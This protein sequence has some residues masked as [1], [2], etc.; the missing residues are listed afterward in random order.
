MHVKM[1]ELCRTKSWASHK[2]VCTA[3]VR[4][5]VLYSVESF[6][7]DH[8]CGIKVK[9]SFHASESIKLYSESLANWYHYD[10][11]I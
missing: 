5:Q 6:L 8:S 10:Y 9:V 4:S 3:C 11:A 1:R 7:K 2:H